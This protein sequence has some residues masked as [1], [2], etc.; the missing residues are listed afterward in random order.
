M[1]HTPGPWTRNIDGLG[2]FS[3]YGPDN[4]G[5]WHKDRSGEECEANARLIAAAPSLL[6][7]LE[8][9]VEWMDEPSPSWPTKQDAE[10]AYNVYKRIT[11]AIAKAK[12][13]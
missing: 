9:V 8:T 2:P 12:G 11:Q 13:E 4:L 6:E 10:S 3:V 7:A 5:I 1:R